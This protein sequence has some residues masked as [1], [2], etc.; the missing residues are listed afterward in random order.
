MTGETAGESKSEEGVGAIRGSCTIS[1]EAGFPLAMVAA[2]DESDREATLGMVD[3]E[4]VDGLGGE[5]HWDDS[6]GVVVPVDGKDWYLQVLVSDGGAD[7]DASI[8]AAEIALDRL[9]G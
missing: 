2:Y 9:D 4:P 1:A 3:A 8:E 7:R 5:A 6:I